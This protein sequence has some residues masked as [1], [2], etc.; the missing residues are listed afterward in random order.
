ML[1][2]A[3]VDGR[4]TWLWS[5]RHCSHGLPGAQGINWSPM[6]KARIRFS[7]EEP[8]ARESS[9]SIS[10]QGRWRRLERR[11][12]A[13][14]SYLTRATILQVLASCLYFFNICTLYACL[15]SLFS[16]L[17]R[18]HSQ[19]LILMPIWCTSTD[20]VLVTV[21][22]Y[23]HVLYMITIELQYGFDLSRSC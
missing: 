20:P 12:T 22:R 4:K 7:S 5:S 19:F 9:H 8:D 18:Y 16:L 21:Q 15:F 23:M 11:Q 3:L 14:L 17:T 6:W 2:A 1:M 10:S 13:M